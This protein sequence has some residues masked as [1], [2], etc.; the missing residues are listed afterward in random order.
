MS[1]RGSPLPYLELSW[2]VMIGDM[3]CRLSRL[4]AADS[5]EVRSGGLCSAYLRM[6]SAKSSVTRLSDAS[7][8]T[9]GLAFRAD[10]G[11]G[12]VGFPVVYTV[13]SGRW[14]ETSIH[15]APVL[16]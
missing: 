10:W 6:A 16:V 2:A 8:S 13:Q 3:A 9:R 4:L 11:I 12:V 5:G 7:R 14:S 15:S 1:E